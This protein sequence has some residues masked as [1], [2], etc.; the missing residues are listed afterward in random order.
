MCA[1]PVSGCLCWRLLCRFRHSGEEISNESW[2]PKPLLYPFI[3][4][5]LQFSSGVANERRKAWEFW[6]A[7][8][9]YGKKRESVHRPCKSWFCQNKAIS[10]PFSSFFWHIY[11][12]RQ[13]IFWQLGLTDNTETDTYR[14]TLTAR[15]ASLSGQANVLNFLTQWHIVPHRVMHCASS[16][17]RISWEETRQSNTVLVEYEPAGN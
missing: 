17:T 4:F 16:G 13:K 3:T 2:Q 7:M 15:A 14:H 1:D 11:L 6:S 12:A 5:T 8:W 10:L 9:V